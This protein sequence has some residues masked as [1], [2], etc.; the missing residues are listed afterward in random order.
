MGQGTGVPGEF[1]TGSRPESRLGPRL[2]FSLSHHLDDDLTPPRPYVKFHEY[3]LLPGAEGEDS[4]LERDREARAYERSLDVR[5]TVVV[6]P[7]L[8]VLVVDV[9]G[10][11]PL[12]HGREVLGEPRLELDGGDGGGR[13]WDKDGRHPGDEP[14]FFDGILHLPRYVEDIVLRLCTQPDSLSEDWHR[15]RNRPTCLY[16]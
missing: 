7:G 9:F 8:L 11:N 13:P 16:D 10:S 14:A 4:A 3:D 12:Q 1:S 6:V 2:G 15:R 5:P